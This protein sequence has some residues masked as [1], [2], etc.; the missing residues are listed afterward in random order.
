M[1]EFVTFKY[2]GTDLDELHYSFL[3]VSHHV[4]SHLRNLNKTKPFRIT[5]PDK[6]A[7]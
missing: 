7:I 6:I 5:I 1:M 3:M 2:L 4:H